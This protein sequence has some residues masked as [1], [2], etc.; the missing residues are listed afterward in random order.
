VVVSSPQDLAIMVVKKAIKMARMMD[1]PLIGL[2]ENMSGMICPHCK[3]QVDLF[4]KSQAITVAEATGIK[5][6]GQLPLDPALSRL[7]DS[8]NI[9]DYSLELF[10]DISFLQNHNRH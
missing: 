6:I 4:G 10:A 2:V 3:Q 5:L 1:V 9:E 7:G 8:G